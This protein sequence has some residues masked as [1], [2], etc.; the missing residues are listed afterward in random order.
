MI[1]WTLGDI[2]TCL[3]ACEYPFTGAGECRPETSVSG[4]STDSRTLERG[5]LFVPLVGEKFDG[6][7]YAKT[8]V[9]ERGARAVVWSRNDIPEW[10]SKSAVVFRVKDTTEAYQALGL[11]WKKKCQVRCI[12]V[13]GSVGKTTT[14]EF[15]AHFLG[16]HFSVHKSRANFNNDIGVPKTLLELT[17]EHEIVITEMGMRGRG[18]IARLVKAAE[19]EVGVV[20]AIGT[21]H[22]ELL[23]SREN[24]ARAKGE[25]VE[26]LPADG[27]AVLPASDD[28]FSLL[29]QLSRAPVA[30]YSAQVD[31]NGALCPERIVTEDEK[32]TVFQFRGR[33]Y[34]LPLPGRHHLHDL[35][36]VLAV[37]LGLGLEPETLLENID[38]LGHPE[39]GA[40]WVSVGGA[41]VYL[42]AYNS[43]PESLRASLGVLKAC[44]GRRLA[45]LGDMLE[46]GEVGPGAH[47][48]VGEALPDY[49]VDLVLG[50]G[51]LT[52]HLILGARAKGVEAHWYD[53]KP[54]LAEHLR[55]ELRQGDFVLIKASRGMALETVV[56]TIKE[57][58]G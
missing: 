31:S 44:E 49:G 24:I 40:E 58:V 28:Y 6:H 46:L 38:T 29:K 7:D 35:F 57:R 55:R 14:K 9:L 48:E 4:V 25:L 51:P 26:G 30:A 50:F 22:I 41:Q 19:P 52:E 56:N 3:E 36:A 45:V 54:G 5:S 11:Y 8:A 2:A 10:L 15:L 43:A 34:T 37:G 27:V 47:R 17:S 21:S 32:S 12:G 16:P 39:G 42:D 18:E 53:E 1:R 13:T 33:E 20:T 23:G